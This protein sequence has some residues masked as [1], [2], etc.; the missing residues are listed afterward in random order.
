MSVQTSPSVPK[1]LVGRFEG[2]D[3]RTAFGWAIAT[4][5]LARK[6][7]VEL[8]DG[9]AVVAEG[10]ADRI[11]NDLRSK[12]IGDG[13]FGFAITL[14]PALADG[15][16][17]PLRARLAGTGVWLQG[18]HAFAE[19]IAP[20][21]A[22]EGV[23]A[24]IMF[25]WIA[26]MPVAGAQSRLSIRIDG[27]EV[28]LVAAE[29]PRRDIERA[30]VG[31]AVGFRF[32]LT[33]FLS[34]SLE[35]TV[36]V[37][38]AVSGEELQGSPLVLSSRSGWGCID[39]LHGVEVGGWAVLADPVQARAQVEVLVD[40]EIIGVTEARVPRPDLRAIGIAVN[41]CGFRLS[42]PPRYYD[43]KEHVLSARIAGTD[44]L[45]RGSDRPFRIELASNID[46]FSPDR[47]AGWI[48]NVYAP[49]SP[50]R[51]DVWLDGGLVG[52]YCADL[53]R[54]DVAAELKLIGK[55]TATGFEIALPAPGKPGQVRRLRLC[56]PGRTESLTGR[57]LLLFSRSELIHQAECMAADVRGR[58]AADTGRDGPGQELLHFLVRPLV[59]KLRQGY[60]EGRALFCEVPETPHAALLSSHDG[61]VDVIVPVYR[62]FEQT[63]ACIESVLRA[64]QETPMELVVINDASTDSKLSEAL[65]RLAAKEGFTLIEN[66]NNLGFVATVN[67]GMR[68]HA[69]RDVVLLNSDTL[70]A[71]GWLAKLRQSAYAEANIGTVTPLSNRA[72]ILSLPRMLADN[73]LP[74][75]LEVADMDALCA[76]ANPGVRVDI[77]TAVGFCMYIKRDVLRETGMFDE[78]LW[79]KGYAEENDFCMRASALG[80]RHV[81]ACDVFVQHHG[82]VSFAGDKDSLV[83][84]N[85]AKLHT[86]YPD[87]SERVE[88]FIDADPL[89]LAR[90]GVNIALMRQRAPRYMLQVLHGWG[91]GIEIAVN[92]LCQGLAHEGETGL[93]LRSGAKGGMELALP[94]G[95]L[96]IAYPRGV[97]IANVAV[98]LRSLGV[99]HV[100]IHQTVGLPPEIWQI[101]KML[102]VA[103]D[104]TLHDYFTVCPRVNLIDQSGAFCVQPE[105]A[106]CERC[107]SAPSLDRDTR[108]LF[109]QLG[110]TVAAWRKF[111]L[112]KLK[113]ARLVFA[114]SEDTAG[115]FGRYANLKQLQ[116]KPHPEAYFE[117]S[118]RQRPSQG[119]LRVAVIGAIG[120]HKGHKLLLDSARYAKNS[121]LP[122]EFVI[123]GYTC[124]DRAYQD[125]DNVE[126]LGAYEPHELPGLLADSGCTV[127]LF[128]SIWPETFSYTLSEAWRSGLYPVATGVGAQAER[129][130]KE[131]IGKLLGEHPRPEEVLQ[132][133]LQ[134]GQG[135]RIKKRKMGGPAFDRVLSA[136]Y[137]IAAPQ[138]EAG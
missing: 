14:P 37:I 19:R 119:P 64:R 83:R 32:D 56:P 77:P 85:L 48:A 47:V 49:K 74:A 15:K 97:P 18:V 125:L 124:D 104:F 130:E 62:G 35:H 5:A 72:T 87:Y 16:A 78:K 136:Y 24:G 88:Q 55:T 103:Y 94:G 12:G 27:A 73:D 6:L 61:V 70:V 128:L 10:V 91:G 1:P 107:M 92:D 127:A 33:P 65:R 108:S 31:E 115:R 2:V 3:R 81:A 23:S 131:G 36:H 51:M 110:G 45:L 105:L 132:A 20:K 7:T 21:G 123:V 68:L 67:R 106:A 66:P 82:A 22:I 137:G 25:G 4:H 11:H 57:D 44:G 133:C 111:H 43:G 38:D 117:F 76:Q 71:P 26:S 102:G 114:P 101:P 134:A 122:V 118:L 59:A 80:W 129:I 109:S 113:K 96:Q 39:A 40:G 84:Q 93:I 8:I 30:E 89:W 126:I 112:D 95:E 58:I 121:G 53:P 29:Y 41:R 99:W 50:V 75:G 42:L 98:D 13:R 34:K 116:R 135:A 120:P 52:T 138:V 79:E 17:H 100:H 90:A 63:I 60:T 9:T 46:V 28:G 69:G 86:L 54:E